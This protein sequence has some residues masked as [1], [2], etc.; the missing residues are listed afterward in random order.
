[1]DTQGKIR[2]ANHVPITMDMCYNDSY[3]YTVQGTGTLVVVKG[4]HSVKYI[5]L[6]LGG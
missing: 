2:S 4:F 1:M 3:M 5:I 6:F